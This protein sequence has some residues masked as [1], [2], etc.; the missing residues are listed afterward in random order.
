MTE[1]ILEAECDLGYAKCERGHKCK[2]L[3]TLKTEY[4]DWDDEGEELVHK[5]KPFYLCPHLILKATL[6]GI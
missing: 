3:D 6:E 5:T 2:S 1:I 4:M